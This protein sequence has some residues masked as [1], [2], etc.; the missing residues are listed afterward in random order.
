[1]FLTYANIF[2]SIFY[3]TNEFISIS[4]TTNQKLIFIALFI[5]YLDNIK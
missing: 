1:M 3:F 2:I 5:S 4:F